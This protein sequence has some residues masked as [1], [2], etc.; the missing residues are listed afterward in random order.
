MYLS[1]YMINVG[2]P[3]IFDTGIQLTKDCYFFNEI[4]AK[5]VVSLFFTKQKLVFH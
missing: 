3:I 2:Q 5:P 1:G 4:L